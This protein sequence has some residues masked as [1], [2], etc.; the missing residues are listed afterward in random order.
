M[1]DLQY[2]TMSVAMSFKLFIQLKSVFEPQRRHQME[3]KTQTVLQTPRYGLA[4]LYEC[5]CSV[6]VLQDPPT[7]HDI[8]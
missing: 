5:H 3:K 7:V 8:A 2:I 1:T 4:K 6:V